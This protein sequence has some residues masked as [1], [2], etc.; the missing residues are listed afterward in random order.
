MIAPASLAG[1]VEHPSKPVGWVSDP[2]SGAHAAS[3]KSVFE[4]I[5]EPI[6]LFQGQID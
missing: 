3:D 4:L 1:F 5:L 2:L 6:G